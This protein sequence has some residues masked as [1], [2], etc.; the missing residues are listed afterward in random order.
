MNT[1]QHDNKKNYK[2]IQNFSLPDMKNLEQEDPWMK[3]KSD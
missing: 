2:E 1:S 3:R